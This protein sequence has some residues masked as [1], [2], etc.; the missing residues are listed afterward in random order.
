MVPGLGLATHNL[1]LNIIGSKL[2]GDDVPIDDKAAEVAHSCVYIIRRH[3]IC[4]TKGLNVKTQIIAESRYTLVATGLVLY[5]I[6]CVHDP[7]TQKEGLDLGRRVYHSP[8]GAYG[9]R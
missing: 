1:T 7:S 8:Y 6:F 9:G 2:N 3:R 4:A 5:G